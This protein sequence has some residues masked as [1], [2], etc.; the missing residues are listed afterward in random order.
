MIGS[1]IAFLSVFTA[2]GNEGTTAAAPGAGSEAPVADAP[3]IGISTQRKD[4]STITNNEYDANVPIQRILRTIYYK[5]I[6]VED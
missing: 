2:G 6:G 1:Y 3:S 5:R 4:R